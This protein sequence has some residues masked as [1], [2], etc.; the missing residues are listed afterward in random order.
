M[1]FKQD[2]NLI[3]RPQRAL[4]IASIIMF[5]LQCR[6]P[7]QIVTGQ[8]HM[9]ARKS[10]A[11]CDCSDV[12]IR[13]ATEHKNRVRRVNEHEL[14]GGIAGGCVGCVVDHKFNE[15]QTL[16]PVII[17]HVKPQQCLDGLDIPFGGVSLLMVCADEF[18][19]NFQALHEFSPKG[20]NKFW[21]AISYE[22]GGKEPPADEGIKKDGATGGRVTGGGHR[23]KD[24]SFGEP[25]HNDH[26][27]IEHSATPRQRGKAKNNVHANSMK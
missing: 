24:Y 10:Q 15:G 6:S 4:P 2:K 1:V 17:D 7:F 5:L 8:Y 21:V 9:V 3:A 16:N 19:L 20:R 27:S 12:R 26:A 11:I 13:W 18:A 23:A 14:V 25:I 22:L